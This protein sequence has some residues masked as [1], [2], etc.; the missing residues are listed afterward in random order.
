MIF[1][2]IVFILYFLKLSGT[3][4][5]WKKLRETENVTR[6]MAIIYQKLLLKVKKWKMDLKFLYKCKNENGYPKFAR[7]KYVKNKRLQMRKQLYQKNLQ[8]V[9]KD[10]HDQIKEL[11]SNLQKALST[12][13][14]STTWMKRYLIKFFRCMVRYTLRYMHEVHSCVCK[15]AI[16]CTKKRVPRF[17]ILEALLLLSLGI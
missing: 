12:P 2:R 15:H 9:I 5:F 6:K 11:Q 1:F 7:W 17:L 13:D 3:S 16:R 14:K 4:G 10:K 8:N